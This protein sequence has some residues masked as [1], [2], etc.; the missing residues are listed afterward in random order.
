MF[1]LKNAWLATRRH[2]W[3][4]ALTVVIAL[5]TTFGTV[6]SFAV[7]QENATAHGSA[8]RTQSAT[9][10]VRPTAA[11][12]A[13]YD[14]TDAAYTKNYLDWSQYSE[15]ANAAQQKGIQFGYT[16]TE[17]VPVR[18]TSKFKAIPGTAD[19][20][21]SDTGGE[22]QLRAFYTLQAAQANDWGRYTVVKGK[23]LSYA[24]GVKGALLSEDLA[25]KNNL[26][27]GDTFTV[28]HPNDAKKT[29]TLTVRG[30]YRYNDPAQGTDAKLAKDNRLNAIYV[31]YPAFAVAGLDPQTGQEAADG[32]AK[33]DLNIEFQL[34]DPSTYQ[35]FAKV[36]KKAGLPKTHEIS[37][38]TLA[39]YER[40]IEPL[41]GVAAWMAPARWVLLGVGGA[42]L[43]ALTLLG[44]WRGRREEI[45]FGLTV[46]ATKGRL[47]WQFMLESFMLT[48]P[49]FAIGALAGGLSAKPIGAA[50]AAGH[51][52]P[53]TKDLMW[54]VVWWGLG[55]AL[56]LALAAMLRVATFRT[57]GLFAGE[58]GE[59]VEKHDEEAPSAG[60]E[61]AQDADDAKEA[62]VNA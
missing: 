46:G 35:K 4:A 56:V 52:T 5:A 23:H 34:A 19:A 38:P 24:Q 25:K 3:R 8:Y 45:G 59:A 12:A 54:P 62:Q 36:V 6:V 26:K 29:V 27:V 37:S 42:L 9:A 47:G 32:W 20:S 49:A 41:A 60:S 7:V 11:T 2:P 53:V 44:A 58:P 22:L 33:P 31:A 51:G 28:A 18:Q 55:A 1:V 43:L 14:G 10:T 57:A 61:P 40:S 16:F 30:L 17:D 13:T 50:L 48:L 21:A 39:A 15:Y